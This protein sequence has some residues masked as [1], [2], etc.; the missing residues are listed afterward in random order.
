VDMHYCLASRWAIIDAS[1]EPVWIELFQDMTARL[2]S[3]FHGAACF[4]AD[5]SYRWEACSLSTTSYDIL[6]KGATILCAYSMERHF[7]T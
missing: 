4:Y 5:K 7:W 1:V 6:G 3:Q 2:C